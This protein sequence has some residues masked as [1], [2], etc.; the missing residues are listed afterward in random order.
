M[1]QSAFI[2]TEGEQR[3]GGWVQ[4]FEAI[5]FR[6]SDIEVAFRCS[7]VFALS[8][9][10][11]SFSD[12]IRLHVAFLLRTGGRGAENPIRCVGWI[13]NSSSSFSE[14]Q[15]ERMCLGMAFERILNRVYLSE[16]CVHRDLSVS[17]SQSSPSE[18]Q[19][20]AVNHHPRFSRDHR[21]AYILRLQHFLDHNPRPVVS[22]GG[23]IR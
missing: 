12:R 21:N 5:G 4:D 14:Q 10:G 8:P 18:L 6:N 19:R 22:F 13:L 2:L 20:Y 15:R 3:N 16:V 23:P 11:I 17:R 1:G 9:A 7:P